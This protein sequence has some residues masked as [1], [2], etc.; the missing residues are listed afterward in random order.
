MKCHLLSAG[1]LRTRPVII[2]L[3]SEIYRFMAK[4]SKNQADN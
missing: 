4:Y 1:Q 3:N 2:I